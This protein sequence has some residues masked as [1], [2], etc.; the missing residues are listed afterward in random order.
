MLFGSILTHSES[1]LYTVCFLDSL[2]Y[3]ECSEFFLEIFSISSI[4]WG[5]RSACSL[6]SIFKNDS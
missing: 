3:K 6:G 5:T 4:S 1:E 2:L